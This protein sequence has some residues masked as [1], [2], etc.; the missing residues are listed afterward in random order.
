MK[1]YEKG[2]ISDLGGG[3]DNDILPAKTRDCSC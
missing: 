2:S 1:S 3:D